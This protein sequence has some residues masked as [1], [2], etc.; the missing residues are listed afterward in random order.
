M[1]ICHYKEKISYNN[2]AK[3][4][5][6]SKSTVGITIKRFLETGSA[7][8]QGVR[9]SRPPLINSS[10]QAILK[11]ITKK[12]YHLCASQLTNAFTN[13]T[14]IHVSANTVR[15]ALHK[16][17]LRCRVA[18]P[19]P[20]ISEVNSENWLNW[21]LAHENWTTRHFRH[22]LWSDESTVS[23]FQ[24]GSCCQVWRELQEE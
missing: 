5:N 12:N 1:I 23:L 17:N 6:Y 2:I 13:Q 20:L 8:P 15:R 10:S 21:C 3:Q 14:N 4:V 9:T 19:K 18:R 11:K 22:M 24:Q 16:L 7:E